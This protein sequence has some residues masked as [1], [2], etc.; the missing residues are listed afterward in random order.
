[1]DIFSDV[2]NCPICHATGSE[3]VW[4][5]PAY[6]FTEQMV[7]QSPQDEGILGFADQSLLFCPSCT[8]VFLGKQH[9]PS[10]LYNNQYQTIASKSN[11]A[12][13]ATQRLLAFANAAIDFSDV[14]LVFDIGANDGSFLRQLRQSGFKGQLAALDPSFS[15]WDDEITGFTA[16]VED[17]DF[18]LLPPSSKTVFFASHVVEHLADPLGF[19]LLLCQ[20]MRDRDYLVVQFP[21]VEPLLR[22]FRF[23]QIHHQHFHYFSWKSLITAVVSAEMEVVSTGLDWSHYGAGNLILQRKRKGGLRQHEVPPWGESSL[24]HFTQIRFGQISD[25]IDVY[26]S[27]QAVVNQCLSAGP[28]VAI[29]AGLMSPIVFYHLAE[30]WDRCIGLYDDEVSKHGTQYVGTPL[31]IGPLPQS[32]EGELVLI[33]GSVS[34][35]A[36]RKLTEIAVAKGARSLIY[37]VLNF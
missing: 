27:Y 17:F 2:S 15:N 8:H 18:S 33:S 6:P 24:Q 1:M 37:P 9:N 5:L 19:F 11:A 21:A 13:D 7:S 10:L 29:G 30:N 31:A 14:E 32:L 4:N 36:G 12:I 16:F 3:V 25:A 35:S 20:E 28:Y 23:D 26:K 22:D 34:K